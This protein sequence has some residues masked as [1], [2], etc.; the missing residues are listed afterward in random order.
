MYTAD[1]KFY[2]VKQIDDYLD[3]D[4]V[5]TRCS[6]LEKWGFTP[7]CEAGGHPLFALEHVRNRLID[8]LKTRLAMANGMGHSIKGEKRAEVLM[9]DGFSKYEDIF[10][11]GN[12]ED[13]KRNP[14]CPPE[15]IEKSF[16][17]YAGFLL[18]NIKGIKQAKFIF[19]DE[20]VEFK[21]ITEGRIELAYEF[22]YDSPAEIFASAAIPTLAT[23]NDH[24]PK[25]DYIAA[26]LRAFNTDDSM[27]LVKKAQREC[28]VRIALDVINPY[29]N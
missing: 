16:I 23:W 1:R 17:S 11:V 9:S 5:L 12:V 2:T 18:D 24:Q 10:K 7:T 22:F 13:I 15:K 21:I 4:E 29:K 20:S 25:Y 27:H 6:L 26:S 19:C 3:T 14:V 28:M 8:R